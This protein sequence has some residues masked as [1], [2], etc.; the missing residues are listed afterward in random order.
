MKPLA[1]R[2]PLATVLTSSLT[3]ALLMLSTAGAWA[4]AVTPIAAIQAAPA[5]F[6][7][8]E[9][10]VEGVVTVPINYRGPTPY[11]GYIQDASGRGINLFGGTAAPPNASALNTI[12]TRV[13]VT[14]EVAIFSTTTIEIVNISAVTS[15]GAATPVTPIRVSTQGA[16]DARWEGTLV[17][18]AG[19]IASSTVTGGARNYVVNDGSGTIVARVYEANLGIPTLAPGTAVI[20]RGAGTNFSGTYQFYVGAATDFVAGTPPVD[21]VAP[22]LVGAWSPSATSVVVT[23]AEVV[24]NGAGTT[25]NYVLSETATPGNTVPVSAALVAGPVVTLTLG[26]GL[27]IQTGYTLQVSNVQDVAGNPIT[28]PVTI[29]FTSGGMLDTTP[30]SLQSATAPSGTSVSATFSEAIDATTGGNT[31]NW[32]VFETAN[33]TNTVAV[34]SVVVSGATA[35]LTLGGTLTGGTGYTVRASG[36]EDLAGNPMPAPQTATFTAPGGGGNCPG[37]ITIASIQANPTAFDG[38]VVTIQGQVYIPSNYRGA[39]ISGYIQDSSGRGINVFGSTANDPRL[40]DIGNIVCITG[41]IDVFFTTVEI[42]SLT[43][44]SVVSSGNPPLAPVHLSTGA[45]A[46][47]QWEGTFI[48]VTG[49]VVSSV[50][51]GPGRNYT[52]NDGSGPVDV[53]VVDTLTGVPV[54]APGTP[55]TARGAGSQFQTT[56]QILVGRAADVFEDSGSDTTPPSVTSAS[57]PSLGSVRVN[58]S[59]SIAAASGGNAANYAVFETANMTNTVAVSSAA[60]SGSQVTLTLGASLTASTGYTVRASNIADLVGNVMPAPQTATFTAPGGGGSCTGAITIASIQAN[61]TAFD[62]QVVTIQGQVYI[63]SNYRGATISGYIQDSSGR[64]INVFGSTANDPRLQDTG[65]IVCITGTIDVFFTTVEITSL[66]AISVVSSGN[67]P[68]TPV[69]LTTAAASNT[70]W[71]GTFIEVTGNV[72]SSAVSG[73]GRNYTVND[74]SGPVDVRVVD[75]L[76][77]VPVF[78]PGTRITARGAGSQF[79]TTFQILVGRASDVFEDTGGGDTTPPS[80]TNAT[81]PTATQLAVTFSEPVTTATGNAIANYAVFETATP[82]N[83]VAVTAAALAGDRRSA[84]LTLGSALVD[85]RS[86]TVRVSNL[87]DDAGNTMPAPQTRAFQRGGGPAITPIATIQANPSAFDGMTVTVEGQVYIPSNYRGTTT[88]GYIQDS[89]GRG[90]NIFGSGANVAAMQNTGNIVRV[91]GAVELFFTTVEISGVTNVTLL[92]SGNPPLQPTPLSTGDA[93]NS[94]WEGT[95]ILVTGEI[96]AIVEQTAAVNYTVNDACRRRGSRSG[97]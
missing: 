21:T 57:A 92:S 66:T 97:K 62:G 16:N 83:V 9:V 90:I 95:H 74:G 82:A 91:T 34:S 31:A 42:T 38:Q 27:A 18:V 45:A 88:S 63:P 89:S 39:T 79:Q 61:P 49:D 48:E 64:G 87:Q 50:V 35:T 59:E 68:L 14:G 22:A 3:A 93:A 25:T 76:T 10:N 23:F 4:Q 43:A 26:S 60:V 75:T 5:T 2:T 7:G 12:G 51:S 52:I 20:A 73:P 56:F 8:T 58:F 94:Q 15:L 6:A 54:F 36:I 46:N 78:A 55:I 44:I 19:T 30:P 28:A 37:A 80:L 71:E 1:R 65:N 33:M 77:G 41:T 69:H 47:T 32:A 13:R 29:E 85:A 81:A 53:R 70:Q 84:T 40:Q 11:T 72:V 86:Y 67:P 17:E 24:Q 96:L